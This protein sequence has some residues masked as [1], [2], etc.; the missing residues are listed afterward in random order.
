MDWGLDS[1]VDDDWWLVVSPGGGD[2]D[3]VGLA[4]GGVLLLLSWRLGAGLVSLPGWRCRLVRGLGWG[5]RL[6][7][8][9]GGLVSRLGR[10][11]LVCRLSGGGLVALNR[12]GRRTIGWLRSTVLRL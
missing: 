10:L 4:W 5:R 6:V 3:R 1:L 8:W 7:S 2:V 11:R 12:L 9:L